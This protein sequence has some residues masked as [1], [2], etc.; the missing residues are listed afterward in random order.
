MIKQMF[1]QKITDISEYYK[2]F[3]TKFK[4]YLIAE[5]NASNN[6][7]VSYINDLYEFFSYIYDE[8]KIRNIQ[9]VTKSV[10]RSYV[11]KLQSLGYKKNSI[12]RK[13]NSL[14]TFF[15]F[16]VRK[17]F[18][19]TN[20]LLYLS[21]IKKDKNLPSF[22]TKE[23]IQKLFSLIQPVDFISA[24]DR[25]IL[26][27]FYSSGLRISELAQLTED[28][29]DLYEG[30]VVVQGKGNK[31]RIVPVGEVALN[32]LKEYIRYKYRLGIKKKEMFLNKFGNKLSVRGIRKIVAKWI[33]KAAIHKKVSPH[34]FR[35]TFATHLLD[36]GCDLRSIQEMLGHKSLSTTNIYTHLTLERL[37][38][39][40]EKVHPRK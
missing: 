38:N 7:I 26:E 28:D 10:V 1:Q 30:L 35:H 11:I 14:R 15:K 17:K 20:P 9:D 12:S 8:I 32:Y 18:L 31:E 2:N 23:E 3:I 25:A 34:T 33:N 36:A 13:V 19:Q 27:L 37:K 22:L 16:L 21:S 5:Q 4:T 39:V 6:T 29:I 40:Y 24:R